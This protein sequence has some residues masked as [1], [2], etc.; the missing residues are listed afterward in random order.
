MHS[1]MPLASARVYGAAIKHSLIQTMFGH[2]FHI[3]LL[4]QHDFTLLDLN[5]WYGSNTLSLTVFYGHATVC[6]Q[7]EGAVRQSYSR[8]V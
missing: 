4:W 7:I 6:R 2:V 1:H 3:S 5:M 8:T